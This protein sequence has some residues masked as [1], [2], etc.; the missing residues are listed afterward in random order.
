M[1]NAKDWKPTQEQI[2]ATMN[3]FRAMAWVQ[4]VK[5][6]VTHYQT[7]I[8]AEHDFMVRPDFR[9]GEKEGPIRDPQLSYLMSDEDFALYHY[10]CNKARVEHKLHVDSEDYCPLL[11]AER[12]QVEAEGA[13]MEAMKPVTGIRWKA[14]Y[15]EN[16]QKY[17]NLSLQLLAPFVK[18][19]AT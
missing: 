8:L 11:V 3:L 12:L 7:K 18:K 10:Q 17:I 5:P 16:R 4:V 6:I 19:H 13:L 15:G 2:D 14:L 1:M 9:D